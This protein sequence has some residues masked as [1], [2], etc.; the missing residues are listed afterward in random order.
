MKNN[1]KSLN[2]TQAVVLFIML[3]VTLHVLGLKVN[4]VFKGSDLLSNYLDY[5][6]KI[7][8]VILIVEMVLLVIFTPVKYNKQALRFY[9]K[10]NRKALIQSIVIALAI[11]AGLVGFR[12]YMN[13]RNPAYR[14]IPLFGLYLNIHTR[15]LYPISIV[16]Q[17]FFIKAFTQ[18]NIGIA[19]NDLA[20]NE[21]DHGSGSRSAFLT[22]LITAMFFFVLHLQYQLYY[23]TGAFLLC[24]FT[25]LMYERDRNIWGAVMIHFALGFLPR[26]FGVL[27][28]IEG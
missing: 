27:Q 4:N 25:G 18:E 3:T 15:W 6:S 20:G 14:E 21:K 11:V 5:G 23:M 2:H 10:E 1:R 16:F 24:F 12:L 26:C 22:S 8:G 19:L 9:G 17:E 7:L 28:I 13:T